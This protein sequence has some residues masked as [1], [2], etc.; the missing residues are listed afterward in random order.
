MA[1]VFVFVGA[2]APVEA[3]ASV[4]PGT[5]GVIPGGWHDP[6]GDFARWTGARAGVWLRL[7]ARIV[8]SV[9]H[10]QPD[11]QPLGLRIVVEGTEIANTQV[12][13]AAWTDVS[14]AVPDAFRGTVQRVYLVPDRTWSPSDHGSSGDMRSLG[15]SVQRIWSE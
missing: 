11:G 13:A 1:Y 9:R 12:P 4:S 7:G 2:H 3:P 10:G 5:G 15:V 14:G 8:A 6:E